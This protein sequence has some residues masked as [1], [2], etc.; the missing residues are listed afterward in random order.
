MKFSVKQNVLSQALA[1]ANRI[2]EKRLATPVLGCVLIETLDSEHVKITSTNLDM[3]VVDT[4]PCT[5]DFSGTYCIPAGLLYDITKKLSP[6]SDIVL[7][8]TDDAN[9]ITVTSNKAS[10]ALNYIENSEFPPVT[11]HEILMSFEL[12]ASILKQALNTSKVAM[13]Q[14]STR[15]QLNGI[16]IHYEEENGL[17]TLRIVAT[18]LFRIACVSIPVSSE[19]QNLTPII[20][21]RRAVGE[22]LHMLDDVADDH[23]VSVKLQNGQI[24]F[25]AML[26]NDI[27][28]VF[29]T[30]LITGTFPEYKMALDVQND[31]IMTASTEDLVN[32]IDRVSTV[33]SDTSNSVKLSLLG[34]SLTLSGV[35]RE[36]GSA[37]ETIDID[38]LS[39]EP[40]DICF[41]SRYLLEIV[42]QID[43]EKIEILF[44][45]STSPTVIK[46][47][48]EGE[49]N[50]HVTFVI[51]PVELVHT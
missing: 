37:T 45:T 32:A 50:E 44:N 9:T 12:Q 19:V 39:A 38:F 2:V 25:D 51:M 3:T 6:N 23:S 49:K 20:I 46:P 17:D 35:S 40:L 18:D 41:N 31:K 26:K 29:S 28:S 22:L 21:S 24:M 47:V 13:S 43:T 11:A 4:V 1:H 15:I 10:F 27:Q 8:K 5:V 36:F 48:N 33:I 42:K 30:R 14:D 34:N 7:N 16:H